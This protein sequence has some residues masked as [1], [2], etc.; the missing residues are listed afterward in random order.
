VSGR[1]DNEHEAQQL[2]AGFFF[3]FGLAASSVR[4]AAAS[5]AGAAAS[6]LASASVTSPG[7]ALP[8]PRRLLGFLVRGFFSLSCGLFASSTWTV[9]PSSSFWLS[10]A[11]A[12]AAAASVEKATKAYPAER[13]PRRMIWAEV[14][15]AEDQHV[16][17]AGRVRWHAHL[18]LDGGEECLEPLLGGRVRKVSDEDLRQD[19]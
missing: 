14:L 15:Y 13:V 1:C 3:F 8:S 16:S 2:T 19:R 18:A 11:A 7:G 5:P 10:S 17:R 12:L 6:P 9:R 4:G